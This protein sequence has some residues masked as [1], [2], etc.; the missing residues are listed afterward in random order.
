MPS[1]FDVD[2]L[3]EICSEFETIKRCGSI[4]VEKVTSKGQ[5]SYCHRDLFNVEY[6]E[7]KENAGR[8][9]RKLCSKCAKLI[10]SDENELEKLYKKVRKYLCDSFAIELPDDINV[11]FATAEKIRIKLK[12]GDQRVVVGFADPKT[13]ELWVEADAPMPNV[14]DVLAHELTH[15]WQFDNIKMSDL[16][17]VE[18]H[19]SY[20]EVQ[21]MRH[22]NRKKFA[23]WQE[24]SLNS[25]R[26]E[27]GEGF[28]RLKAELEAGGDFNSF[29]YMLELF[30]DGGPGR[31]PHGGDYP[32]VGGDDDSENADDGMIGEDRED[33]HGEISRTPDSCPRYAYNLLSENMKNV[34]DLL[35]NSI[36]AFDTEVSI[37]GAS[38]SSEDVFEV[39]DYIRRDSPDIFWLGNCTVIKNP[40]TNAVTIVHFNYCMTRATA[41]SRQKEIDESLGSFFE[42]VNG[43]M[44]DYAVVKK[45]HRLS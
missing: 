35:K 28:R 2:T 19:A 16:V 29:S 40:L 15:M 37:E 45:H 43:Q 6:T 21:Y 31:P 9:N 5:C 23:E 24:E 30:G 10:V 3:K 1:C 32:P 7:V 22:E 13:R 44:S 41:I 36:I 25:R 26:D 17:Y 27:Y 12:T 33:D 20:V 8:N 14:Q 11:R 39:I 4:K 42:S 38:L 18:G 34:Y